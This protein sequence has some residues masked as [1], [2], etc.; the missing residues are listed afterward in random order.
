MRVLVTGGGGFLGTAICRLLR[1]RG[2]E[3]VSLARNAYPQLEWLAVRQVQGD[4]ASLDAVLAA[5]K[6]CDAIVHTAAKAGAWGALEDYYQANV[7]GTDHVI[8]AC[9]MNGIGRLVHTST[10]SVVH[11]GRDLEGVDERAPIATHFTAHY[12]RTKAIAEQRVLQANGP[13]LA[14]VA[15]R[16]HLVWGPGDNHLLP[17]LVRR[18][19]AG[20]LRFV[21]KASKLVDATYIDNAAPAHL[22][23]LDRV[24]PGAA[25]AGR[26]YFISNDA[27]WKLDDMVNALLN[28]GGLPKVTKRIP[29]RAAHALGHVLETVYGALR[30]SAEPPMTRFV[31]EQ[32]ATAH[33]FDISAAKRD[34]GYVVKVSMGEGI[35][36]VREWFRTDEGRHLLAD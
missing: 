6:G 24:R 34:L 2:D 18:A 1:A 28:A 32:L 10:P 4:I 7:A 27:P 21:G 26:A 22:D 14:T 33:W 25:C 13:D 12:P 19:R 29:Y 36:R 9:F 20:R 17:R 31:A 8:A 23:A 5:S 30:L 16:P 11:A 35:G 15:L 3:V